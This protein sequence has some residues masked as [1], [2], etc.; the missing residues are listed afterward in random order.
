MKNMVFLVFA[1]FLIFT[2]RA[3]AQD[4]MKS[5]V[6]EMIVTQFEKEFPKARDVEWEKEIDYYK[7]DL[8]LKRNTD[9]EVWYNADGTVVRKEEEWRKSKLPATVKETISG[10]FPDYRIDQVTR[11]TEG[12]EIKFEVDLDWRDSD[13]NV[14]IDSSG[15]VLDS[16]RD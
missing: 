10:D 3:D 6:P 8:E 11:I 1:A 16:R 7:V 14:W 4:L 5:E 2:S 13:L 9:W 15:K 12:D